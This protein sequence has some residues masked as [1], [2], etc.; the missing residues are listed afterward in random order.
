MNKPKRFTS[1]DF[2]T[3]YGS[4][5]KV[6]SEA[7]RARISMPETAFVKDSGLPVLSDSDNIESIYKAEQSLHSGSP[8]QLGR[9]NQNMILH[10][11]SPNH[12]KS[13]VTL[14]PAK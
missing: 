9:G 5:V 11:S 12:S 7:R 14:V 6:V 8:P 10:E 3:D 4:N 13:E 2:V 1:I